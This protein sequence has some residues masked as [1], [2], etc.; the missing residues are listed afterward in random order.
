[1]LRRFPAVGLVLLLAGL[2]RPALA[3]P[4]TTAV[5]NNYSGTGTLWTSGPAWVGGVAPTSGAANVLGFGSSLNQVA[6]GYTSTYANGGAAFDLNSLVFSSTA[7][8]NPSLV[9]TGSAA[10]DT[11]RFNTNAGTLPSVWQTGSG[12][13]VVQNGTA[14]NGVTLAGGTAL[15]LLGA[16]TGELQLTANVVETGGAGGLEINQTGTRGYNTGSLV[17]L[18]GAANTFTGGVLL[19]GGNLLLGSA[20]GVA[21]TAAVTL[22]SLGTGPLTVNQTGATPVTLQ[23]DPAA[24]GLL[25]TQTLNSNIVLT[26]GLAVTGGLTGAAAPTLFGSFGG[27]ISGPGGLT[28]APTQS[29]SYTFTGT[30]SF[31]GSFAVQPVGNAVTTASFG[32]ATVGTGSAGGTAVFVV[33]GNSSL[34]FENVTAAASRTSGTASLTLNRGNFNLRGNA[35][36]NVA[37]AFGSL[38]LSGTGS[39]SLLGTSAAANTQ[40][41]TVGT[42]SQGPTGAGTLS[43]TG[44]NL[45]AG[46]AGT[47]NLLVTTAPAGSVGGGTAGTPTVSVLPYV[48]INSAAST[49]GTTASQLTSLT[50]YDGGTQRLTPLNLATEY[51]ASLYTGAAGVTAANQR[52]VNASGTASGGLAGL[53]KPATAN[54]LVLDTNTATAPQVGVS[55]SGTGTLTLGGGTILSAFSGTTGSLPTTASVINLGGLALGS[56]RGYVHTVANLTINTPITGSG[57]LVKSGFQQLNLT[58]ANT[59]TGGLF[60]NSG[61][62]N[63]ADDANLGAAGQPVTLNSGLTGTFNL[64]PQTLFQPATATAVT[65]NRPITVGAAGTSLGVALANNVLTLPGAI[66]GGGQIL[67]SGS[68][69]ALLTGANTGYT[70]NISLVV[71]TLAAGSEA[72]LGGP[73]AGLLLSGGTFQPTASF[74]LNRDVLMTATSVLFTPSSGVALTLAGNLTSQVTAPVLLKD[75]PGDVILTAMNTLTGGYQNGTSAVAVRGS[76]LSATTSSG[77]TILTGPNG[78]LP[79]ASTVLALGGGEVVLDNGTNVNNNRIGAVTVGMAGGAFTLKGNAAAAVTEQVGAVSFGASTSAPFGGVLTIDQPV[80]AGG[81]ATT[82]V[83]SAGST[84]LSANTTLGTLFV[85]ATNL[86]AVSGDRGALVLSSALANVTALQTNGLFPGLVGATYVAGTDP[87][88]VQP[89]TFLTTSTLTVATPNLNQYNLVPFTTYTPGGA[90]GAGG[91]TLTYDVTSATTFA[92]ASAANALRVNG[93]F[94]V[95]LGGG[96]LTLTAGHVLA[97]GSGATGISNGTLTLGTNPA[98]FTVATGADLTVGAIV[99]GTGGLVKSGGGAMILSNAGNTVSGTNAAGGIAVAAGV[100][101]YGVANALPVASGVLINSGAELDLGN[102]V[103]TLGWVSAVGNVRLGTGNLTLSSTTTP[104][105]P[106]GG[107]FIGTAASTLTKDNTNTVIVSG[108]SPSFSGGVSVLNGTLTTNSNTALGSGPITLGLN[109][110]T[111]RALLTMGTTVTNFTNPITVTA[112]STPASAHTIT[113]AAAVATLASTIAVNNT[114]VTYNNGGISLTGA[115]L[116]LSGGSGQGAGATTQTGV[117]SGAG[118]LVVLSG[119]WNFNGANTYSG[120]TIFDTTTSSVAGIGVDSTGASGPF[121]TGPILFTTGLGINLRADGGARTVSNPVNLSSTGGYFGVAGSNPLTLSGTVDLQGA[122]VAQTFNIQNKAATTLSGVIQTGTS[123]IIKN[124]PGELVLSNTNTYTGTTTVNAGIL[125]VAGTVPGTVTV[126][127]GAVLAGTGTVGGL[128]TVTAGGIVSPGN[129]PG[130][131]TAAGA[132]I[133]AGV[134]RIEVSSLLGPGATDSGASGT[135]GTTH[136]Q[137]AAGGVPVA[138]STGTVVLVDLTGVTLTPGTPYSLK[139]VD[140]TGGNSVTGTT[141]TFVSGGVDISSG[142]ASYSIN[143][144]GPGAG[145]FLNFT[146]V[147]EP[148]TVLL[149]AGLG[150]AAVRLRR[151]L[152]G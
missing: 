33:A 60:H 126:N 31:T 68:G 112:G 13:V 132:T 56:T 43:L 7:A 44:T 25:A 10:G 135:P 109:S 4:A 71:G 86:G 54:A 147:P 114:A 36:A 150:L 34:T 74:T 139:I 136:S 124:G 133:N 138:L 76:N 11:L 104:T 143:P 8:S 20:G 152:L 146:P 77:R 78:A 120:G 96:T 142:V 99:T 90:L 107:A 29:Q 21:P 69:V 130:I 49:T 123:G 92:G 148:A 151:R 51:A 141:A 28:L 97:T 26:T 118:G 6:G 15:R 105:I 46:G 9:L 88:T 128:V 35:A 62:L 85:R 113:A 70:G 87:T 100:L 84:V 89:G 115:G 16:G 122:T 91:A 2:A 131:L 80:S 73:G 14:T 129:S 121:G 81:Q 63:Y 61:L 106:F 116:Q 37:E 103:S 119:N 30:N 93:G 5:W 110:G 72:A 50:R 3:Q 145:I 41:V 1:M 79:L 125:R 57:G 140:G 102:T 42:L 55:A 127:S 32:T 52:Y 101:R 95:D 24:N 18:A 82:L 83:A 137:L 67:K 111:N 17:R 65:V 23:F 27:T 38:T 59:F 98:R 94:G 22:T 40:T 117:I 149:V 39:V 134:L 64:N 58:A 47:S 19:T 66:S 108:D 45:G 48:F 12:R 53:N 144:F 75:G